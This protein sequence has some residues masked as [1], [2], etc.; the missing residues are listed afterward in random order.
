MSGPTNT[1]EAAILDARLDR[2]GLTLALYTTAPADD[3]TGGVEVSGG[4]YAVVSLG[5]TDWNAAVGGAP[6]LKSGP[7]SGT[8]WQFPSPTG[9]WSS[10][11]DITHFGIKEGSTIRYVGALDS[12]IQ[13][14]NGDA[15]PQFDSG[16]L[17]KVQLGDVGDTF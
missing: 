2:S 13:V 15:P 11:A 17:V 14:H 12:P 10:G 6:T 16:H 3:G 7:K 1:E 4:G 5:A 8:T 9:D